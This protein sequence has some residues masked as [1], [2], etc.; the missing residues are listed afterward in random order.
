VFDKNPDVGI[1]PDFSAV[2]TTSEVSFIGGLDIR[3]ST[4]STPHEWQIFLD[5]ESIQIDPI[6]FAD[7]AG[8]ILEN[9]LKSAVEGLFGWLPGWA[10]DILFGIIGGVTDLIRDILD[11][12]DDFREWLG[13]LLNTSFDVLSFVASFLADYFANQHP[14]YEI[15]DPYP[16]LPASGGLIPVRIPV[17]D[18]SAVVNDVEMVV[19]A[20]V[21]A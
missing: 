14:I 13:D 18:L 19:Q 4:A 7:S 10:K 8:D 21:G 11:I 1:A 17:R 3:Y 15:E 20:N 9:A 12:G 5:P 16:M 6:D 2:V